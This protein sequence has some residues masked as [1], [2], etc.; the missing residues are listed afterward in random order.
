MFAKNKE[1]KRVHKQLEVD[2]VVNQGSLSMNR[3]AYCEGNP[4]SF[5]DLFGLSPEST[6]D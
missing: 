1:G 3:Y 5:V 6:Q 2:F 4:V